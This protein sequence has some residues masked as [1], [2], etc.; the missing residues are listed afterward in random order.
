MSME[1]LLM[2]DVQDL[3]KEGDIV[4]VA[5]GYARNYLLPRSLAAPVT[6]ATRR[7]LAK[8][9]E[10][11]AA[12]RETQLTEARAM[13]AKLANASCTIPVKVGQD[14]KMYGSVTAGDIA[15]SLESQGI[16]V[17]RHKIVMENPIKELGVFDVEIRVDAEVKGSIKVWVVEE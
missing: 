9:I 7:R 15:D 13:A 12:Q 17:D 8:M 14:E 3:G 2:A 10:Q 4:T 1:V 11:R 16:V 6:E 5:D